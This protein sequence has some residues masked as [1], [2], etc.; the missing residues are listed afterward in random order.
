MRFKLPW[1]DKG[2]CDIAGHCSHCR[3]AEL[4]PTGAF[5]ILDGS[6]NGVPCSVGIDFEKCKRCGDCAHTCELG[7]VK[8]V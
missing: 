7:A 6:G 5:L 4:C 3:A 1:I 8:M 2:K